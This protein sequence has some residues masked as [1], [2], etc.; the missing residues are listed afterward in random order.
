M[1]DPAGLWSKVTVVDHLWPRALSFRC[2]AQVR[3][4][5]TGGEYAVKARPPLSPDHPATVVSNEHAALQVIQK[6]NCVTQEAKCMSVG[7]HHECN[8][9]IAEGACFCKV[10]CIP[11]Y[12]ADP[13]HT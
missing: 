4:K 7:L 6:G 9:P 12:A 1:M 13:W 11:Q 2:V 3:H 8:P 10:L 5:L